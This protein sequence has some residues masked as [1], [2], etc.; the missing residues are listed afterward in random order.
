LCKPE[1]LTGSKQQGSFDYI[2]AESGGRIGVAD[3][4]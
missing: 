4:I 3:E 2:T 1:L